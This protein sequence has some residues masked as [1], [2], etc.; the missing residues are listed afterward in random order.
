V[1]TLRKREKVIA[2]RVSDEE[3]RALQRAC[4]ETDTQ[5]I[6]AF[7]REAVNSVAAPCG[8]GMEITPA[9][10]DSRV[11]K[12][13]LALELLTQELKRVEQTLGLPADLA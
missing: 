1:T 13:E 5:S 12:I 2:F 6:S 11:R 3:Y 4:L 7:A 10:L 8:S 9:S